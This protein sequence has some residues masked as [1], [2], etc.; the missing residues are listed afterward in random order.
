MDLSRRWPTP[1]HDH[2][3]LRSRGHHMTEAS[4]TRTRLTRHEWLDRQVTEMVDL[5][6]HLQEM[7][8]DTPRESALIV[9]AALAETAKR[10]VPND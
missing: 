8:G 4:F 6:D 7:H 1:R 10:M 5:F 2:R 3:T 9:L